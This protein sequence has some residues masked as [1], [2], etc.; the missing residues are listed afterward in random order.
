MGP[1]KS[2]V[3]GSEGNGNNL[4][5]SRHQNLKNRHN[6]DVLPKLICDA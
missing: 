5:Y 1:R 6:T 2:K 4:F 3:I